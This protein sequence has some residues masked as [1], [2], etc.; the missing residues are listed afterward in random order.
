MQIHELTALARQRNASDIHIS[1][2]L[3]LSLIHI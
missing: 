1:Q 2:G 3:P